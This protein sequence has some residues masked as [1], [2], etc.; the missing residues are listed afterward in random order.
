MEV[1]LPPKDHARLTDIAEK[2]GRPES[3]IVREVMRSYLDGMDDVREMLDGRL[4]DIES[5]RVK[6]VTAE[7]LQENLARRKQAFLQQRS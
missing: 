2:T 7:Q 4:E 1:Q 6:P 5:G 3:E